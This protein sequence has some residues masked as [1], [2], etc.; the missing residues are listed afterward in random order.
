VV[1]EPRY[2]LATAGG[3]DRYD[4]V[5]QSHD[6]AHCVKLRLLRRITSSDGCRV[7][8]E[9]PAQGDGHRR[10]RDGAVSERD[11]KVSWPCDA[12]HCVKLRLLRRINSGGCRAELEQPVP[13]GCGDGH[14]RTRDGAVSERDDK[15]SWPCD[16]AHFVKLRLLRRINSGG[17]RAELEQPV[18]AGCGHQASASAGRDCNA[19][20]GPERRTFPRRTHRRVARRL[21]YLW[22]PLLSPE[23][24]VPPILFKDIER[25]D[26]N[27]DVHS[28]VMPSAQESPCSLPVR[29]PSD[30]WQWEF[31]F[32]QPSASGEP[33]L[34]GSDPVLAD[35]DKRAE[36]DKLAALFSNLACGTSQVMVTELVD[37]DRD[38][39]AC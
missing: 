30:S 9:E 36:D 29:I 4:E 37:S 19:K 12:A 23:V 16:A 15:V 5:F 8:L 24:W 17:C 33:S 21:R 28:A 18:P 22:C 3:A 11:D 26:H 27:K 1:F 32:G 25:Q 39:R 20:Q 7:E 38:R 6:E 34:P 14:R 2:R 13:A 10:T 35:D 31:R